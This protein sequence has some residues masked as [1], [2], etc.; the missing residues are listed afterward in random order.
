M[1][2]RRPWAT[3]QAGP[4]FSKKASRSGTPGACALGHRP[5]AAPNAV[6]SSASLGRAL[7]P[8]AVSSETHSLRTTSEGA[9]L[10][11]RLHQVISGASASKI[12]FF[13]SI[14]SRKAPTNW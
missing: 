4:F 1:S 8:A 6:P 5:V 13:L 11:F 9:R 7:T 2:S 10:P 3:C 12:G 14:S